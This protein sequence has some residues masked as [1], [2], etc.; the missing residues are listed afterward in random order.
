MLFPFLSCCWNGF[1]PRKT[2]TN[3]LP[4]PSGEKQ[5]SCPRR[6][7]PPNSNI[8]WL[9]LSG[10]HIHW[11]SHE[12]AIIVAYWLLK[13]EK[14]E[15]WLT[16]VTQ[17]LLTNHSCPES[18]RGKGKDY[19]GFAMYLWHRLQDLPHSSFFSTSELNLDL[20]IIITRSGPS[21]GH[22]KKEIAPYNI[23][24]TFTSPFKCIC[25]KEGTVTRTQREREQLF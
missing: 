5:S 22:T 6:D 17:Q 19:N 25:M 2:V 8:L 12:K 1:S 20:F 15:V 11:Q 21:G 4:A 14:R 13:K 23:H 24:V 7:L 3:S 9:P 10:N 18:P 16:A